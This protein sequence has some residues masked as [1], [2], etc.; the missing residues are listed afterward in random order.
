MANPSLNFT[1]SNSTALRAPSQTSIHPVTGPLTLTDLDLLD[2]TRFFSQLSAD[3]H[4]ASKYDDDIWYSA[5]HGEKIRVILPIEHSQFTIHRIDADENL[6]AQFVAFTNHF[7]RTFEFLYHDFTDVQLF[8]RFARLLEK[9]D[10][11]PTG[12]WKRAL[13]TFPDVTAFAALFAGDIRPSHIDSIITHP[14]SSDDESDM[15]SSDM[16]DPDVPD[17]NPKSTRA[18]LRKRDKGKKRTLAVHYANM[19][20][21]DPCSPFTGD[22]AYD[23]QKLCSILEDS[24]YVPSHLHDYPAPLYSDVILSW[25]EGYQLMGYYALASHLR[26]VIALGGIPICIPRLGTPITT[27]RKSRR[28]LVKSLCIVHPDLPISQLLKFRFSGF[29]S[30]MFS[31][32]VSD[33]QRDKLVADLGAS[34]AKAFKTTIPDIATQTAK[35]LRDETDILS[36]IGADAIK[37]V[38]ADPVTLATITE[39]AGISATRGIGGIFTS[40]LDSVSSSISGA[41]AQVTEFLRRFWPFILLTIAGILIA[42]CGLACVRFALPN[43]FG[44]QTYHSDVDDSVPTLL[45]WISYKVN[46]TTVKFST[47][48]DRKS[49]V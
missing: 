43:V 22:L 45:D 38:V 25:I 29:S 37:K 41:V 35:T 33:E 24:G 5:C 26:S 19:F 9:L 4:Q 34:A 16:N 14:D 46:V 47:P 18:Q 39:A 31:A 36:T 15:Y 32:L 6:Q 21:A 11:Y 8:F 42:V 40:L 12:W 3:F 7:T 30:N 10:W 28:L 17:F 1:L 13:R 27:G 23:L 2:D 44:D 48:P 20:R 49:V